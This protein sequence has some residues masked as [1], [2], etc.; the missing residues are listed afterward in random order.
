[1]KKSRIVLLTGMTGS[2]K[3]QF[4]ENFLKQQS[5]PVNLICGDILQSYKNFSVLTNNIFVQS[6]KESRIINKL[7]E[8]G[9]TFNLYKKNDLL[10]DSFNAFEYDEKIK[11]CLDP[12]RL[13][14]IEGGTGFYLYFLKTKMLVEQDVKTIILFYDHNRNMPTLV[15]KSKEMFLNG[16]ISEVLNFSKCLKKNK[17]PNP[18]LLPIGYDIIEDLI[19]KLTEIQAQ[20]DK[21]RFLIKSKHLIES[22]CRS[23]IVKQRH[24]STV[25]LK[26]MRK[27]FAG[28]GNY[29]LNIFDD[30]ILM[31][32]FIQ[33]G[34][35]DKHS[36]REIDMANFDRENTREKIIELHKKTVVDFTEKEVEIILGQIFD[37]IENNR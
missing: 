20:K 24:Y 1:M 4:L 12:E 23:F 25:Q 8:F 29:W 26:Y 36:N 6:N 33:N 11:Q 31:N 27:Y 17:L 5:K 14:L 19:Q 22:S 18:R 37:K 32:E 7:T 13:N 2:G 21:R 30:I 15:N 34:Y 10:V 9:G 28:E 35:L 16:A 3:T